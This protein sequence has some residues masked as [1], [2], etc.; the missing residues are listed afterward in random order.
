[1]IG[2]ADSRVTVIAVS[3]NLRRFGDTAMVKLKSLDGELKSIENMLWYGKVDI[4]VSGWL[5]LEYHN[6]LEQCDTQVIKVL[7]QDGQNYVSFDVGLIDNIP[8]MWGE[9][10]K[11]IEETRKFVALRLVLIDRGPYMRALYFRV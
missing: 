5:V 9:A 10:F 1:M 7:G 8:R 6:E 3:H 4:V 11:G 2:I